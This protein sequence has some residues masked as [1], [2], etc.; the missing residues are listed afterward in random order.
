MSYI[1]NIKSEQRPNPPAR[2]FDVVFINFD[3][4]VERKWV[5]RAVKMLEEQ[6]GLVCGLIGRDFMIGLQTD[7]S[8]NFIEKTYASCCYFLRDVMQKA[9]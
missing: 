2:P 5:E 3:V 1:D 7:D 6:C 9:A 4:T 8:F